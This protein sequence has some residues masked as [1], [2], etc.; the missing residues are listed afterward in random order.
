MTNEKKL[1]LPWRLLVMDIAGAVLVAVGVYQ[2]ISEGKGVFSI[3]AGLL[4]MAPLVI[5]LINV[6]QQSK[7]QG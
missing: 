2:Y 5:Y 6:S 4:L 1:T 7:K 3:V